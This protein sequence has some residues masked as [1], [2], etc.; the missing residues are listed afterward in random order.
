MRV[1]L[2][3]RAADVLWDVPDDARKEII[4]IISATAEAPFP[5]PGAKAAAFGNQC[6]VEYMARGNVIQVIDVGCLC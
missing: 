4:L 5:P 2:I 3:K 6:W 1:E